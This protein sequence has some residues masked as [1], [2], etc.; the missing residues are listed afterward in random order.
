MTLKDF[1]QAS[2][3][4]ELGVRL[5]GAM[6]P[7]TL[8]VIANQNDIPL[9]TKHFKELMAQI[10]KPELKRADDLARV[11]STWIS[12]PL[13]LARVAY[14]AAT[15]LWKTGV[16][17][18]EIT[19]NPGLYDSMGLRLDD[20]FT[21]LND[22]RDRAQ[23]A[24][25]IRAQWVLAIPRDEPRRADDAVRYASSVTGR[26]AAVAGVSL[27]GNEEVQPAGQFE[28]AFKSAEKHD[29]ARIVQTNGAGGAEGLTVTLDTLNP[30][31]LI[32]GWAAAESPD[33]MA[34][35]ADQGVGVLAGLTRAAKAGRVT[36]AS[37]YP[38]RPLLDAGVPVTLSVDAPSHLG[39]T[40]SDAYLAVVEQGGLSA[41]DVTTLILNG[42]RMSLLDEAGKQALEAELVAGL[43]A[44]KAS[45]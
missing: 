10:Q 14:D 44:A 39:A 25:G 31:R 7:A 19:V 2:P 45:L 38:L 23:R 9:T 34:R 16:R 29:I 18:A 6:N 12:T 27:M 13:E 1:V 22:G 36:T 11:A 26:R 42:A 24:W 8:Q 30:N 33:L 3:K 17:Y 37:D 15:A 20:L 28:R 4:V 41:E 43:E 40:L 35:L 32:E 5:E 21:A